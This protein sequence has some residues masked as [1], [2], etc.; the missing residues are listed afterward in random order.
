LV[1]L[2][3]VIA[4]IGILVALLLPAVQAAREASRRS[5]CTNNMKQVALALHNYVDIERVLPAGRLG[6]DCVTT[7][8]Y[9]ASTTAMKDYQRPGTSGLVLILPQM[10]QQDLFNKL[11]FVKGAI[12]P[13]L[14][15]SDGTITGWDTPI[16]Q[17]LKT[18]IDGYI[19]PSDTAKPLDS[20]SK[21][22]IASYAFCTGSYGPSDGI[23][24][25]VKYKNNGVFY[26]RDCHGMNQVLDGLSTTFFLGEVT[27]GHLANNTN[28][29]LIASRHNDCQRS[30]DN[31]LNTQIGKGV[32]YS[33]QNGA[34]RSLHPA[35][36]NFAFGDGHVA[37]INQTIA[38]DVYRALSTRAGKESVTTP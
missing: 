14:C 22:A 6:C 24:D 37:F 21:Y 23:S 28:R 16:L 11:G 17:L 20:S 30:T 12:E 15:A 29:W 2:L 34:F 25:N 33:G 32:L 36:G 18:R 5:S 8:P 4:I 31:P 27:D 7:T 26:Y 19:C 1:E 38:R 9:C 3:V 10:E 35:G 13:A